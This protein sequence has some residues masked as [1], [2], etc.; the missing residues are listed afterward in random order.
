MD[1]IK[2]VNAGEIISVPVIGKPSVL[3]TIPEGLSALYSGKIVVLGTPATD[4]PINKTIKTLTDHDVIG[5]VILVAQ[6]P[7]AEANK[8]MD[9]LAV[10]IENQRIAE[11][12]SAKRAK[13]EAAA[14]EPEEPAHGG[15]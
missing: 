8:K 6:K 3:E 10:L 13:E 9:E 12:V 7:Y 11:A 2:Q 5:D 14:K 1:I 15:K 4:G